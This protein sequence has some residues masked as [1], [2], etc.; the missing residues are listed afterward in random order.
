MFIIFL[1]YKKINNNN[2]NTNIIFP[3]NIFVNSNL[4]NYKYLMY[5]IVTEKI[6]HKINLLCEFFVKQTVHIFYS[7]LTV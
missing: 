5:S 4:K 3:H 7:R 2:N 6:K 1:C